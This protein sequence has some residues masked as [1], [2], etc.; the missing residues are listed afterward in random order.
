MRNLSVVV[1]FLSVVLVSRY[2]YANHTADEYATCIT[3]PLKTG[4]CAPPLGNEHVQTALSDLIKR[5]TVQSHFNTELI[6]QFFCVLAKAKDT[7]VPVHIR[8]AADKLLR[9]ENAKEYSNC[10]GQKGN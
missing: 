10:V 1:L 3:Q 5:F 4:K 2:V 6:N 8:V 9:S 7:E